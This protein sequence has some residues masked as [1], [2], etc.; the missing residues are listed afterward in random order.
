PGAIE[1]PVISAD[2]CQTSCAHTTRESSIAPNAAENSSA[3][4]DAP[5]NGR[6]LKRER[7][8]SGLECTTLCT[9]NAASATALSASTAIVVSLPQ[10]HAP[11]FT[12]PSDSA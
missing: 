12:R 9:V 10:P 1:S 8:M 11:P 2:Q 5:V 7:S 3:T 4:I 6:S